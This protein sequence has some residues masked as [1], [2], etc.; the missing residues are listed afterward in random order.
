MLIAY[1]VERN[2]FFLIKVN[3]ILERFGEFK[4]LTAANEII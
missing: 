1:N 4:I 2:N 3:H